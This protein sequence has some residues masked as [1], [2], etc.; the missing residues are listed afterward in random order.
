MSTFARKYLC[1]YSDQICG[2][3]TKS[4]SVICP[5]GLNLLIIIGPPGPNPWADRFYCD[6]GVTVKS[7]RV[8]IGPGGPNLLAVLVRRTKN[9]SKFGL[10][11]D[12]FC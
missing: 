7:V 11:P 8:N 3:R 1:S 9:A 12:P 5:P 4:A 10:P 2:G 6:T